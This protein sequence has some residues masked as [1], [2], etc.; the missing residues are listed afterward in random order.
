MLSL[1]PTLHL[2]VFKFVT[3]Q[4]APLCPDHSTV[5]AVPVLPWP[6]AQS[7]GAGPL[8]HPVHCSTPARAYS[9]HGARA[10]LPACPDLLLLLLLKGAWLHLS[11]HKLS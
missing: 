7:G 10:L 11:Y 1:G 4:T 6:W 9:W 2:F 5:T 8:C 3:S